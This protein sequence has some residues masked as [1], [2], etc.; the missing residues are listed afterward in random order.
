M[1]DPS[2]P[3]LF[4]SAGVDETKKAVRQA[5]SVDD[6]KKRKRKIE[7]ESFYSSLDIELPEIDKRIEETKKIVGSQDE[8]L[9]FVKSAL[10]RFN[11][12]FTEKGSGFYEIT[13]NDNRLALSNFGSL[14]KKVT[15]DPELAL[16]QPDA[17]I[18]D[19]GRPFVR[20]LI[21]LVKAEFF[22]NKGLYGR[23]AYFFSEDAKTVIYQ[24]NILVRFTVGLKE[25]RVIEELL[26]L[27]VDSYA[28][29]AMPLSSFRTAQTT[30][31]LS[32]QELSEH[33]TEA[34]CFEN[35]S[36]HDI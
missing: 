17:I 6:D 24:Y 32:Q 4:S 7:D 29:E 12:A 16:T 1:V 28:E 25:K 33:L 11:S 22:T 5:F 20:K 26:T 9:L 21:E 34:L 30:R 2:L 14:M 3:D 27:S 19:A 13:I 23:N 18:L 36:L 15:F 10:S 8:V 35:A 31:S